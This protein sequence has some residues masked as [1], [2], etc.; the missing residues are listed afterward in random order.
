[1]PHS[2]G[3]AA[4]IREDPIRFLR[5]LRFAA[6]LGFTLDSELSECGLSGG[7]DK[8]ALEDL[9]GAL[10][11]AQLGRLLYELKR[12]L[13]L[14]NR[15]SRFLELLGDGLD[16]PHRFFFGEVGEATLRAWQAAVGRVRRL[17]ALVMEGVARGMITSQSSQWRGRKLDGTRAALLAPD[18]NKTGIRENDWAELLLAALC[19]CSDPGSVTRLG[20]R[21]QLSAAMTGNV[22]KLQSEARQSRPSGM[23]APLG[24]C[25]LNGAVTSS[26]SPADFWARWPC[27]DAKDSTP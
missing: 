15:P 10:G 9:S 1:M 14:H 6:R 7:D 25:L 23:T 12:A 24:A 4:S 16:E 19:W 20:S 22:L 8:A 21:L 18:W 2:D 26:E 11:T 27:V 3:A 17:E 13:L 5:C